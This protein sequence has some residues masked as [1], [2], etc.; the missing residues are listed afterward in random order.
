MNQTRTVTPGFAKGLMALLVALV[1]A[2]ATAPAPASAKAKLDLQ[3]RNVTSSMPVFRK[4]FK[5]PNDRGQVF[6]IQRS[7]N[8]NTVVYAGKMASADALATKGTISAYWRRYN[9][10]GEAK[11][12]SGLERRMA[13]G[14]N[15]KSNGDGTYRVTFKALPAM[16]ATLKVVDGRPALFTRMGDSD[17]RLI[18]AYL[19]VDDGGLFPRVTGLKLVGK[20]ASGKYVTETYRVT[21]G[22]L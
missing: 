5:R 10:S 20:S 11:A 1:V 2:F 22:E 3:S 12:L 7:P 18:Y 13:Y 17:A 9:T 19:D 4:D 15:A 21:G 14:A 6:F 8:A 16:V